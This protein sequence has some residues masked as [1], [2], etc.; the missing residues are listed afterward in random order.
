VWS[1]DKDDNV[2]LVQNV[3]VIEDKYYLYDSLNPSRQ[4]SFLMGAPGVAWTVR[5]VNPDA[6]N[7]TYAIT[8]DLYRENIPG[9]GLFFAQTGKTLFGPAGEA[10][11]GH[12]DFFGGNFEPLCDYLLSLL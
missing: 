11:T 7:A 3:R 4:L 5:A 2:I 12:N 6:E 1:A 9:Y 10:H 8:G